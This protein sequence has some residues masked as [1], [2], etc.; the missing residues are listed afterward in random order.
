MYVLETINIS[1]QYK[2][3]LAVNKVNMHI[4][5]G[6][7]YG[8]VGDNGAGKTTIIRLISGLIKPTEGEYKLFGISS[9]YKEIYKV[10]RDVGGIVEKVAIN[11]TLNALDN[12]KYQCMITNNKKSEKELISLLKT[13]G[14]DYDRLKRKRTGRYSLG[15]K[16]RLGLAIAMVSDPKFVMLDEPMNGLDPKGF[17]ALRE[18]ILNLHE[19]GVT[20]LI[21]S[22]ILSEL[23]KICNK[24][25]FISHGKLLEELT[26]EEL[27]K[28]ARQKI[29]IEKEN[30]NNFKEIII[31][32]FNVQEYEVENNKLFIFDDIDIN[33]IMKYLLKNE[34]A[35]NNIGV[36]QDTIEDY[37]FKITGGKKQWKAS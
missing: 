5:E 3:T 25:G 36:I 21:S 37:Y 30:I 34:I 11:K 31:K 18:A 26:I 33:E 16:Q 4:E 23:D 13:V 8:F 10:K 32:K 14:L 1:K 9:N 15:M 20:F 27:H 6:D 2:D 17:V 22:H 24:V 29:F 7:I 35:V 12:L 19:K 28:K